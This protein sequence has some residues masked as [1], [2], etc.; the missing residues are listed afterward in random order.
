MEFG[1]CR[2]L[3]DSLTPVMSFGNRNPNFRGAR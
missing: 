3:L 1:S 2:T